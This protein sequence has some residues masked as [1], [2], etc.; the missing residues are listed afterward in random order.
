[1]SSNP[2]R[3]HAAAE[4]GFGSA[5]DRYERGRPGYPADAI[6]FLIAELSIAPGRTV[7]DLAAGTGKFTAAIASTGARIVAVEP[8]TEM[9]GVLERN[10][11]GV[12][13]LDGTA[14]DM[15]FQDASVDAI[16]VAQAFHWFDGDRAIPEIRRVLPDGGGLGLVWNVRDETPAWSRRL[17]EIFDRLA[18]PRDPRHKHGAWRGAFE[19]TDAFTPLEHRSFEH[20]REV[21]R[22]AFLDR[23][24]SVSYVASAPADVRDQVVREVTELLDTDPDLARRDVIAMPYR[25]DVSVCSAR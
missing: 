7:V 17:T 2:G 8:V 18:G 24:L 19:R 25:T 13:A 6:A 11:P 16:V 3:I 4:V 20:A 21:D 14:E 10:I 9:R 5:A 22:E 15:P 12:E 23:V 1:M